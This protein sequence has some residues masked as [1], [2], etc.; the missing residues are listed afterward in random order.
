MRKK[1]KTKNDEN[2]EWILRFF[3]SED[4][5]SSQLKK[6]QLDLCRQDHYLPLYNVQATRGCFSYEHRSQDNAYIKQKNDVY[7][8]GKQSNPLHEYCAYVLLEDPC[9]HMGLFLYKSAF[10][11]MSPRSQ[12]TELKLPQ[13]FVKNTFPIPFP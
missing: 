6:P 3:N 11:Q 5:K 9:E 2:A 7:F 8:W 12:K 13:V 4:Q 1:K 10:D